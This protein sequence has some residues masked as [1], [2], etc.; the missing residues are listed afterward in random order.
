MVLFDKKG[1][2]MTDQP[3]TRRTELEEALQEVI[4]IAEEAIRILNDANTYGR[5]V[6]MLNERLSTVKAVTTDI[7]QENADSGG[8]YQDGNQP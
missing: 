5:E 2:P 8:L 4:T 6:T 3:K 7:P 1:T